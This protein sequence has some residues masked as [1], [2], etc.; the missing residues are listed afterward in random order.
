MSK[1]KAEMERKH[2]LIKKLPWL[3]W[4]FMMVMGLAVPA[5]AW[6][7]WCHGDAPH[8][9]YHNPEDGAYFFGDKMEDGENAT[10][11]Q[12]SLLSD[13]PI[14]FS[15]FGYTIN[16]PIGAQLIVDLLQSPTTNA[17]HLEQARF[18]LARFNGNT[19]RQEVHG[20]WLDWW[21]QPEFDY[22]TLIEYN[23]AAG[24]L[25]TGSGHVVHV[26]D[27]DGRYHFRTDLSVWRAGSAGTNV[28]PDSPITTLI[29]GVGAEIPAG[30]MEYLGPSPWAAEAYQRALDLGLVPEMHTSSYRFPA[31][32]DYFSILAVSLYEMVM[33]REITGQVAFDDTRNNFGASY[34]VMFPAVEKLAYI[35]VMSGVGGNMANPQERLTREQAAVLLVRLAEAVGRPLPPAQPTFTDNSV[36]SPWAM[37]AVGAIQAAG[38]IGGVGDNHFAPQDDYTRE[39]SVITILRLFEM[40]I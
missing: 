38:I 7:D 9:W 36:I 14:R 18:E 15:N 4:G 24:G 34:F 27:T 3:A 25:I 17:M 33:E 20:D 32:R 11:F 6:E 30:G 10:G 23:R 1:V 5:M 8:V 40:L 37:D 2:S 12:V 16:I 26:F 29:V 13:Q 39:Q 28:M 22:T 19:T 31:T 21:Y 35:G